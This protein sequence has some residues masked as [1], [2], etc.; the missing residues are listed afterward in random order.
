[1]GTTMTV[2]YNL[3]ADLF[4][5]HV[6]D[7]RAYLF[8]GDRLRQLTHDHTV[9]QV[10]LDA[11]EMTR[12]EAAS[13]VLR[14]ALLQ[15]V[16]RHQGDL[17]VEVQRLALADGDCLLLCTDGLTEMVPDDRIAEVLG[18]PVAAGEACRALVDLALEAGG[19]DNV[20]AVVA[21]YRLPDP[22]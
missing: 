19:K 18:K 11:G 10:L 16:G 14:H 7:S 21:R 6:G 13:H 17:V 12:E 8:R 5:A 15:A 20:T 22:A 2:A 1:M 3:G 9:V 4:V